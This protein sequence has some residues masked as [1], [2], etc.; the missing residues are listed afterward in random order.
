MTEFVGGQERSRL[1]VWQFF[2]GLAKVVV[3]GALLLQALFFLIIMS[4]IFSVLGGVNKQLAGENKDGPSLKIEEGSALIFNPKGLLSEKAP[5]PDPFEEALNEAFGGGSVGQ[6]SVHDLV[7]AIESAKSDDRIS[8]MVLDLGGLSIPSVYLSKAELLADAIEDF[9]ESGKQVIAV[10]DGY[11]QNQ[12]L[13]A[14][15]ANRIMMHKDGYGFGMFNGYGSY[16]TYYAEFLEKLEV[17]NNVFRVGEFKSA[18]EPFFRNDM[19]DEAKEA[20]LAYLNVMWDAYTARVDENRKLGAGTTR[21]FANQLPENVQAARGDLP[22]AL[23]ESGYIDELVTRDQQDR[24]L[25][26][27]FGE[28]EDGDLKSVGLKKY[29]L[30]VKRPTDRDDVDNVAVITV[31]GTIVDGSQEAGVASGDYVADELKRAREDDDIKAV[32]LRIDSPGGSAF[33]SELMRN[34]VVALQEAGKPVVASMSS[35][36]ASGGYWIAAPADMIFA[37]ET[38]I[39]GSIGIFGYI[40]TFERLAA[41]YGVYTDG[42]GTAPL[43]EAAVAGIGAL[44]EAL[45]SLIQ[46]TIED[47]YR[48]FINVVATGRDMSPEDVEAIAQGRVWI[49]K[50]AKEINLV[51]EFGG[52]EDAIAAAAD[53][54]G[55]DEWD[56]VGMAKEKTRFE[57]FLEGLAGEAEERGL[58]GVSA[59]LLGLDRSQFER[60]SLGTAARL[61]EEQT[62]LEASFSDPNGIYA[63][64][65]ECTPF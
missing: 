36:A 30:A 61:I 1:T 53:K 47:G 16:R 35:L 31:E 5:E 7:R 15:E 32:V 3:G 49:G 20:N 19:S 34:E 63:R 64:C 13:V 11:G 39:T 37:Q 21:A 8:G 59:R 4:L 28:D 26:E 48:D 18:L 41:R 12:Y 42:V 27:L 2:K 58:V 6:V 57:E 38:T 65:L 51:D 22:T 33:A 44:P 29:Q 60:T 56:V 46:G 24:I 43:A 17:T 55:L 45:R 9:R 40:P 54:A 10:G 23:R 25:K 50:T 52:L 14:S 62:R